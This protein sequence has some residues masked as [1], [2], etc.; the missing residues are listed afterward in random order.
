MDSKLPRAEFE[1]R[2]IGVLGAHNH[3]ERFM[4]K[5][6]HECGNNPDYRAYKLSMI[7]LLD[8]LKRYQIGANIIIDEFEKNR[9]QSTDPS[10]LLPKETPSE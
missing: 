4:R 1:Q 9:V 6:I 2:R 10:V 7:D 3:V 5:A 8:Q